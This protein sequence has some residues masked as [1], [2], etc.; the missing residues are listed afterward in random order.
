MKN[1]AIRPYTGHD[2]ETVGPQDS[3]DINA[4]PAHSPVRV[5][6]RSFSDLFGRSKHPFAVDTYQRG[7]VWNDE[8][9]RQLADDLAEY[10]EAPDPKPPYY[11]GTV[12]LHFHAKKKSRFIIDG[13][14][15]LTAL[16][17]LHQI[18][19][20]GLPDKCA[21]TYSPQS[22]RRIRSAA[23]ILRDHPNRP[24]ADIFQHIVFTVISVNSVDLAFTFFDTQNNR[25]VP[26]HATDLLKA[27]HLRAIDGP[28]IKRKE[29][30]QTLCARRWEGIQQGA[31]VMS[32]DQ[33]FAPSLFAKF[34]WRARY[35]TGSRVM[36]G[37][38]D[39]LME[40]FQ[41]QT[42]KPEDD[43]ATIP[44]YRSRHNRLGTALSLTR[45]GHSEIH[46]NRI[47]LSPNAADLPFAIRQPIQK[48]IGFFLYADKYAALLRHLMSEP[49]T[50]NEVLCFRDVYKKLVMANSLFL[51]EIFLL[52]SLMYFD[53]FQDEKLWEFSLWLEHG[54]GAIRLSKQQVRYEAAQNFVKQDPNNPNGLNLLDVIATGFRPEQIISHLKTHHM[55]RESYTKETIEV[56]K[57][58]RGLYKRAVL[59]YFDRADQASLGGKDAWIAVKL[60]RAA[61]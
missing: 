56:G 1:I 55:H 43:N 21:L 16:C 54:L 35:W 13:Q 60:K 37:G 2:A 34:L 36:Y 53:Q 12:L 46:T 25:G 4:K 20:G 7:F 30:L 41:K 24:T 15:R 49:T 40:E 5:S 52:A 50:A 23:V 33:E 11:M 44:L 38:H 14:Q 61:A 42:W 58:V 28:T 26:L 9:I 29:A 6:V 57:G 48:G 10:Q 51:R 47:S 22:A 59:A 45:D 19:I 31:P 27:Y 17:V 32:H 8:K 3:T 39:A 18:L